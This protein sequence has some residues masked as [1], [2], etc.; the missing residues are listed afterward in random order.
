M[1]RLQAVA[2]VVLVGALALVGGVSGQFGIWW[3][4]IVAGTLAIVGGLTLIRVDEPGDR[5][6]RRR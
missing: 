1:N 4:M 2:A 5:E 6:G 3:G